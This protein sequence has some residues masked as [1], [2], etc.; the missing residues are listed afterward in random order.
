MVA[1]DSMVKTGVLEL[2]KIAVCVKSTEGYAMP[3]GLCRQKIREFANTKKVTVIGINLNKDNQ[4]GKI[5]ISDLNELL[6][7]SFCSDILNES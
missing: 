3:C 1:I 4:I 6:P 5:F 7:F 2:T